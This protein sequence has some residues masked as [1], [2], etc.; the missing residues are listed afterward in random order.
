MDH[1]GIRG[2]WFKMHFDLDTIMIT[3]VG[4]G[5]VVEAGGTIRGGKDMMGEVKGS[6]GAGAEGYGVVGDAWVPEV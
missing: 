4:G 1:K 2:S 3:S 6:Q 5:A